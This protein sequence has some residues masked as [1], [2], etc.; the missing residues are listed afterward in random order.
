PKLDFD[1][2]TEI[3]ENDFLSPLA[4]PNSTF[5]IDVDQA[6]WTYIKECYSRRATIDRD[7]VK[8]EEM[9]NS[10]QQ[11][12]VELKEDELIGLEIDRNS[13]AWN[14]KNELVTIRL[15]AKDLPK[16]QPRISHNIVLLVDVSGSMEQR[17]KL[18]LLISGLKE[19][20]KSLC[21]TDRISIVT[22]AGTS[23]VVLEPTD[24]SKQKTI[25]SAISSL[26]SGG[27]TN[28]IG[29]ITMAYELAEKHFD[30]TFNNR[31]IL[32][33][34]GD[35][36]VGISSPTELIEYISTKRGE[37]IYITA[38][39]F[40]MGNYNSSTLEAIADNGDGNHFYI[41]N[42]RECRKVL[43][44]DLGNLINI[45]RDVKLNVE[46]NPRLVK[47]YRLIG[48]ENRLM[49][50]QDFDDDNKDGGEMGYNHTVTAVY[51][52]KRGKEVKSKSHFV[53]SKATFDNQELAFVK[54]R[55]KPM[56]DSTSIE[57]KFSLKEE[58]EIV[59]NQLVNL[60]I[61]LGLQ[62]RNS[63]FKGNITEE[64]LAAQ[65]VAFKPKNEDERELKEM[66]LSLNTQK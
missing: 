42:L 3:Y 7:A 5:G 55:Y 65:A 30:P 64:T 36:N 4:H 53:K 48:Y 33:T 38:L 34:D 62:L 52:I 60:I 25:L 24:C 10:F 49:P 63:A 43:M 56:E 16:D 28:G 11:K 9:I 15:K 19:F 46:F 39:G 26:Q 50:S 29:G 27:S 20:V 57:Q 41:N 12:E 54:L 8:L 32:A 35:F 21:E 47:E 66:V 61:S 31:I 1:H 13:C 37:G 18:P 59:E 22:Y 51:E 14:P 40:G 44:H 6:S 58:N 23:G 17:N 45:A 2:F